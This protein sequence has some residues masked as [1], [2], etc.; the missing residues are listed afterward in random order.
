MHILNKIK[1]DRSKYFFLIAAIVI[2]AFH[3]FIFL[4]Y[5]NIGSF[6]FDFQSAF[7][8]LTF[9]KIWF[10]KNGLSVPCFTPSICCGAP[11]FANPQSEF[12]SPIQF[13]FLFLKPLTTIK[14]TFFLYSLLSFIG[15]YLLLRNIFK[16]SINASLIGSTIFLFNH[17][18]AFHF[19]SGHIGWDYF[20]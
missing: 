17:Y 2:F 4:H 8:R 13:L 5:L 10:L 3:Q 19:L 12:Y 9:G 7:S 20:L 14:V 1:N 15:S 18:F 11:Y 6:H 16:L